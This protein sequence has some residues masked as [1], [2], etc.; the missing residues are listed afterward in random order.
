VSYHKKCPHFVPNRNV[1]WLPCGGKTPVP[2]LDRQ[3]S[4]EDVEVL[5]TILFPSWVWI[6]EPEHSFLTASYS[7]DLSSEHSVIRRSLL[8]SAWY[9][10]LF[11]DRFRLA[12][13][14]NQVA[15]YAN[16]RLGQMV[17]SSVGGDGH[18]TRLRHRDFGR[19]S[20]RRS[21]ALQRRSSLTKS[22]VTK[23]HGWLS[24][25]YL[26]GT[27]SGFTSKRNGTERALAMKTAF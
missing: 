23:Q 27:C 6:T 1:P 15:Q 3:Q 13:D 12:G 10:R 11:G 22:V 18:G 14:R 17:A 26:A 19:S 16:N 25:G 9:Q 21:G 7:L 2:A 24:T 8:P 4:A 5:V 20:I